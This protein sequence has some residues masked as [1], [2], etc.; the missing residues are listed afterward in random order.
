MIFSHF[1]QDMEINAEE[2]RNV[3][4]NVVKK[5]EFEHVFTNSGQRN[6]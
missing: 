5:R 3:L 4:N 6:L 2:L 1:L